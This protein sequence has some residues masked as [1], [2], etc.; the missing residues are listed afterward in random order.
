[1]HFVDVDLN[2]EGDEMHGEASVQRR[3]S[4]KE[5]E[6]EEEEEGDPEE[7]IDVLD[8]L[9]GKGEVNNGS[10]VESG[11][12]KDPH[13]SRD[14]EEHDED[15]EITSDEEGDE[16]EGSEP[17]ED[18]EIVLSASDAE[19]VAPEALEV[20]G[21]FIS[22][23]DPGKKRKAPADEDANAQADAQ[24][25]RKRRMIKERTEGGIENEFSARASG[26]HYS[27]LSVPSLTEFLSQVL[28]LIWMIC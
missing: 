19:D 28:N 13:L 14:T 27:A 7:F 18:Q 5:D 15:V 11:Q 9:D 26:T 24:R 25:V 4:E 2:E 6:T 3:M 23:L 17:E 1:V 22:N 10:D 20:L 8:V 12:R 16:E 21:N